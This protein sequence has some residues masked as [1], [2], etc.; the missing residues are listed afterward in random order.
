M[1]K[2]K[3]GG[4]GQ[5]VDPNK[6][7]TFPVLMPAQVKS[8]AQR[9]ADAIYLN[10]AGFFRGCVKELVA[11]DIP[12]EVRQAAIDIERDRAAHG[13]AVEKD[14]WNFELTVGLRQAGHEAARALGLTLSSYLIACAQR[15]AETPDPEYVTATQV[16]LHDR[17]KDVKREARRQAREREKAA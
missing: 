1:V 3:K 12:D 13:E 16:Y 8:D 14:K 7:V 10:S 15:L 2:T 17:L 6:I 11:L 4:K 5:E 9:R